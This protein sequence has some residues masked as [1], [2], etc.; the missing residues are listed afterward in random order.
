[1][2]YSHFKHG[3]AKNSIFGLQVLRKTKSNRSYSKFLAKVISVN[4]K[5]SS[6][7][8]WLRIDKSKGSV[9]LKRG[10]RIITYLEFREIQNKSNPGDFDYKD[11]SRK[12]SI[13]HEFI[14]DKKMF[15]SVGANKS[16]LQTRALNYRDHLIGLLNQLNFD[17]MERSLIEALL[18]GRKTEMEY[19]LSTGYRKAGAMHLLAI[20]GLHVGILLFLIRTLLKPFRRWRLGIIMMKILPIFC[21]W[22]FAFITGL[23]A[24]V[25]RAVIMFSLI[26]IALNLNRYNTLNPILFSAFFISLLWKPLYLFDPGF[27]LS[28]LAVFSI[29]NL[30]P[31]IRVLLRPKNRVGL[32]LWNLTVVS[33]AAQIGVLPLILYYFHGFSGLFLASSLFLIPLLGVILGFGYLLLVMLHFDTIPVFYIEIY[34]LI[35]GLMNRIVFFL[36]QFDILIADKVFFSKYLLSI[37]IVGLMGLFFYRSKEVSNGIIVLLLVA[38]L[39]MTSILMESIHRDIRSSFIVFHIYRKSLILKKKGSSVSVFKRTDQEPD[40]DRLIENYENEFYGLRVGKELCT[41]N[42]IEISGQRIMIIDSDVILTDFDFDPDII[43]LLNSPKIN[44]KRFLK[45][46]RPHLIVADGSNYNFLKKYWLKTAES[47]G[48]TFHDTAINGAFQINN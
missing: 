31:R 41:Q 34:A 39:F 28:Y 48:I 14:L 36:A 42:L 38:T 32:Y 23:S 9:S 24:S 5:K 29:V 22:L 17:R 20:S 6:G 8:V 30:G 37:S 3:S 33:I 15:I 47:K 10:A 35:I 26:S 19:E 44:L 7:L 46:A 43:I 18:L 2:N 16:S 27:Q 13:E 40:I 4:R 11:Y 25:L 21:L 1:M 12:K 45:K